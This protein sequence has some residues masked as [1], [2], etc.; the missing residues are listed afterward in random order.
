MTR[1][2][3]RGDRQH[4]LC[5][6]GGV[7][8]NCVAN[9]KVL[10]EGPFE[11]IWIQPAAGDAGGALG[12][13]LVGLPPVCGQPR[14]AHDGADGMRGAYLPL[15]VAAS[16]ARRADSRRAAGR[17]TTAARR[18]ARSTA[19]SQTVRA[20][21]RPSGAGA[22]QPRQLWFHFAFRCWPSLPSSQFFNPR[23]LVNLASVNGTL[24]RFAGQRVNALLEWLFYL[25]FA[26]KR[27]RQKRNAGAKPRPQVGAPAPRLQ[28]QANGLHRLAESDQD[29]AHA[30]YG[31][32]HHGDRLVIGAAGRDQHGSCAV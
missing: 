27:H 23:T 20:P 6:A 8:L 28:R 24:A 13:A 22:S 9:G 3:A 16:H 7:A 32:D 5:L 19:P 18:S 2:I 10:R 31:H 25:V 14:R 15:P 26:S 11:R 30:D 29:N 17:S 12:A 1:A 4:N 21:P